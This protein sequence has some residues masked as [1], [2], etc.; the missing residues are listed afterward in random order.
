MIRKILQRFSNFILPAVCFM[1]LH[2]MPFCL[3]STHLFCLPFIE[4]IITPFQR[5]ILWNR[6]EFLSFLYNCVEFIVPFE[7][8]HSYG[9]VLT[10]V[11]HSWPLS[12]E[13]SLTC[14][15]YCDTG[16]HFIKVISEDPWH[17]HLLPS[18]WQWS[19]NYLF[20]QLRSVATVDRSPISRMQGER[21]TS[22]PPLRYSVS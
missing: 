10:Y 9:D 16:L 14:R 4:P 3:K 20:L 22:T 6:F 21:S 15:T 5:N 2:R 17:S 1:Q 12:S 19:C 7:I 18:L 11:R 13:G 8:F